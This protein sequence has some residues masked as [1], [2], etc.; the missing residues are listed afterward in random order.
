MVRI[1]SIFF[2]IGIFLGVFFNLYSKD[3]LVEARAAY[4]YP[5]DSAFRSIYNESGLYSVEA[6]YSSFGKIHPWA[7]VGMFY[8]SGHTVA[9]NTK[10]SIIIVPLALG[11]KY[12][13]YWKCIKPYIGLG[14]LVPYLHTKDDSPFVIK[15]RN[16]W[17]VGA[18]VKSGIIYDI[19]NCFFAD[20]FLDYSW[21]KI[22]FGKTSKTSGRTADISGISVG[23][24]IGY[25]F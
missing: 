20:L 7:S 3:I 1:P 18:I 10:T 13:C 8:K 15:V 5:T 4:F 14:I 22:N 19:T 6:S 12:Q 25:H 9:E 16:K 24:G 23:A 17:G 2:I 11:L 21:A